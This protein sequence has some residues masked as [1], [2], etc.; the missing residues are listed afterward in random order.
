[1]QDVRGLGLMVGIEFDAK[2]VPV[3][4]AARLSQACLSHGMMV[5]TTSIFE[6]LRFMPPLTVTAEEV[7]LG[8]EIFEKALDDTFQ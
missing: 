1:M 5:L 4:S 2:V 7:A 6:T 8:L 3:G